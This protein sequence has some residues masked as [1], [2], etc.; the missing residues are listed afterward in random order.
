M[1][2]RSNLGVF[3]ELIFLALASAI[4]SC[5]CNSYGFSKLVGIALTPAGTRKK[6]SSSGLIELNILVC[7]SVFRAIR[8]IFSQGQYRE[9]RWKSS[10]CPVSPTAEQ[11]GDCHKSLNGGMLHPDSQVSP[12][13]QEKSPKFELNVLVKIA[14]AAKI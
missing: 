11:N 3:Q 8:G 5:Q 4:M 7:T 9:T 12:E 6:A 1:A 10:I 2:V 14:L 13:G